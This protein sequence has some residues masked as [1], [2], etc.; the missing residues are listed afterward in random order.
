M[1]PQGYHEWYVGQRLSASLA[2]YAWMSVSA[3]LFASMNLT[4]HVA[5][6]HVPWTL[7]AATRAGVGALVAA[8]VARSRGAAFVT[9]AT[10]AMWLRTLFGTI[11]IMCTFFALGSPRLPLGDAATL[12]NLTPIFLALLAPVVL[13]ERS[14]TRVVVAISISAAG[15]LLVLRPPLLFG[16]AA[17]DPGALFPGLVAMTS[18]LSASFAM[19]MIRRIGDRETPES[20]VFHFSATATVVLLAL[21]IPTLSV[22][23]WRDGAMMAIAGVCGGFGQLGMTRAYALEKAARVGPFGYIS[24]VASSAFG[25]I[26]LREWP[27]RPTVLGMALVIAGGTVVTVA[28]VRDMKRGGAATLVPRR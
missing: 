25:A 13:G 22:P 5:G 4:A 14:G 26:A 2:A 18:S 19:M 17:A 8:L 7:V 28:G 12:V 16:G 11:S 21:S 6:A 9:R 27:S 10:S 1:V 20:V 23:S 3:L 24:V 15:A